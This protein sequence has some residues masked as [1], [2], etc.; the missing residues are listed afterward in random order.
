MQVFDKAFLDDLTLKAQQSP[1]GRANHNVHV[2]YDE[3][4]QRL[5]IA[6]EPGSY[7]CPHRHP[8]QEKWEFFMAARGHMALL[9]FDDSGVLERRVELLPSEGSI[10]FEVPPGTWHTVVALE[11][12]SIFAEVKRGPYTPLSD[13]DFAAWAPREGDPACQR[14]NEWFCSAAPG[15]RAPSLWFHSRLHLLL[16]SCWRSRCSSG[17]VSVSGLNVKIWFTRLS[18]VT[19]GI[20]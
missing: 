13:K 17:A 19:N 11:P 15:D 4:V 7:V 16:Y 9:V 14:F 3:V 12:G 8:E 20:S 18:P 5:F 6:I 1:R 2:A 10:G